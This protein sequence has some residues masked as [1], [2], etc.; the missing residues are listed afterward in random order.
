VGLKDYNTAEKVWW[1]VQS[2][3]SLSPPPEHI[4]D[5]FFE[6]HERSNVPVSDLDRPLVVVI[7]LSELGLHLVKAFG[8]HYDTFAYDSSK[9]RLAVLDKELSLLS[10]V[11]ATTEATCFTDATHFIVSVPAHVTA[12]GHLDTSRIRT[13]LSTIALYAR[14]G[15]TIV[16]EANIPI[17]TT[18]SLLKELVASRDMKAGFSP[19]VRSKH[20]SLS[21]PCLPQ[22]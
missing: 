21:P 11:V 22:T 17:N 13:A 3:D 7:G 8:R 6:G 15:S 9:E 12:G 20:P 2:N 4:Q 19:S 1:A 18:Q 14:P 10:N 5:A 16:L